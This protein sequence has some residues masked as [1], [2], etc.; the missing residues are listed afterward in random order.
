MS[1]ERGCQCGPVVTGR[2]GQDL[3]S[4]SSIPA[5]TKHSSTIVA[6]SCTLQD[7]SACKMSQWR[8]SSSWLLHRAQWFEINEGPDRSDFI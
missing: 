8:N 5:R 6:V 4:L 7:Q 3:D 1:V 2:F